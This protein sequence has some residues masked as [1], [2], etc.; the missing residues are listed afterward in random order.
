MGSLL[1]FLPEVTSSVALLGNCTS[2]TDYANPNTEDVS[3]RRCSVFV[4]LLSFGEDVSVRA[5]VAR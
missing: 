5:Q 1:K 2:N 4:S 3:D